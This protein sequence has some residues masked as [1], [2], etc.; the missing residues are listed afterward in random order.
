MKCEI[1]GEEID[2][3]DGVFV[4]P[5]QGI[6]G[7]SAKDFIY[8]HVSCME[9]HRLWKRVRALEERFNAAGY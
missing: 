7:G 1:C 4:E 5:V 9:N 2:E 3:R 6:S 8:Q